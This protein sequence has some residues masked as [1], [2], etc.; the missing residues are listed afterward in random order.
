MFDRSSSSNPKGWGENPAPPDVNY[1]Y[2]LHSAGPWCDKM[3]RF[4][5]RKSIYCRTS[6][7]AP[8]WIIFCD[9]NQQ[10]QLI[11]L[12]GEMVLEPQEPA[13]SQELHLSF[14]VRKYKHCI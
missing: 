3:G 1:S 2:K 8:V 14:V 13:D 9:S 6:A 7:K 4:L 10:Q 12:H 5:V 11:L